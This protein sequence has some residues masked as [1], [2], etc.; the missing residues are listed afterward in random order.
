MVSYSM[1]RIA[2]SP[3]LPG[4]INTLIITGM[5]SLIRQ[6]IQHVQRPPAVARDVPLPVL[7][8]HQRGR[9]GR[10]VLGGN[11]NPVIVLHA[12]VNLA[13]ED[14]LLGHLALRH[15]G[16][17]IGRGQEHRYIQASTKRLPVDYVMK[18]M[19]A[20]LRQPH[21]RR[22]QIAFDARHRHRLAVV[23]DQLRRLV[24]LHGE[25]R[26]LMIGKVGEP[27]FQVVGFERG[28]KLPGVFRHLRQ[29]LSEC[30]EATKKDDVFHA[31]PILSSMMS[32]N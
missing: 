21:H 26:C 8:D 11:V 23:R 4:A 30:G 14:H 10:I 19:R 28:A 31:L 9:L 12:R 27:F 1:L 16:L 13:R 6:I 20:P 25:Q 7:P 5:R 15:V 17:L 3:T 18:L 22:P 2:L 32:N 29:V 24:G